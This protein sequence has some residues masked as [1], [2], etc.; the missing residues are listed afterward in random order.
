MCG[1][2]VLY[3]SVYVCCMYYVC[4]YVLYVYVYTYTC[5][6]YMYVICICNSLF[7]IYVCIMYVCMCYMYMC[8]RM[9]IRIH[10]CGICMLCICN[11]L[12]IIY[13]HICVRMSHSITDRFFFPVQVPTKYNGVGL[14]NTQ[15]GGAWW[16]GLDPRGGSTC[17]FM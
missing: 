11:S 2:S 13:V 15:V 8:I 17:R 14:S 6:W 3:V 7:I 4:T 10:V 16:E 9:C 12:S 1:M 5:M